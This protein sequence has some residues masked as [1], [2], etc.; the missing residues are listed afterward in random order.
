MSA[1]ADPTAVS[2][3]PTASGDNSRLEQPSDAVPME[4]MAQSSTSADE[5][6]QAETQAQNGND[7]DASSTQPQQPDMS[8]SASSTAPTPIATSMMTSTADDIE[9]NEIGNA[10]P[11]PLKERQ[12][13]IMAIGPAQDEIK[14]V[15]PGALDNGPVCNI[16]LL[17]TTGSR[18]PYK[19]DARYL[20]RR[21]VPIPEENEAGQSDPFSISVYTLKELILREWRSDWE[22]KP[23][24]PS[25]I[26]LIHFGKLLD[27]KES[28]KSMYMCH[29]PERH[30]RQLAQS[31]ANQT[32]LQN[33]LSMPMLPMWCT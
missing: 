25:S 11:P 22:S 19:I 26:R 14:A 30:L 7:N 29:V 24:S 17:L 27:D 8:A 21:N 28:L 16:T 9:G 31:P 20:N 4:K 2:S 15:T 1:T 33:T 18:H 3:G 13:S 12:D 6:K 10:P 23:A 5:T 32:S